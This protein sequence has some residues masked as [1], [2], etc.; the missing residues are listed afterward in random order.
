ML[1]FDRIRLF[2]EVFFPAVA[3]IYRTLPSAKL[4]QHRHRE[5][6]TWP[7][8]FSRLSLPASALILRLIITGIFMTH[9]FL[10][11]FNL[12]ELFVYFFLYSFL[13][14]CCEVI[15]ATLKTGKFVNRGFLNGPV[16]PIYGTGVVLL[17]LCLTPLKKYP[18][19]VFFVSVV[20]CSVL[21]FLTGFLLEKVFH[22]KW[23]DYS[24]RKFNIGGFIC[25]EMSLLWGV[26]AIAVLYGI[27][28][29]FAALLSHIPLLAG[30][31]ILGIC[32]AIFVTDLVFTLLQISALGKRL[33]ELQKINAALRLGSDALGSAL[34]HA[35]EKSA[36][37]IGEIRQSG[38]EKLD[39]LK[40]SGA[41]AIE[42]L[43]YRNAK[44]TDVLYDKIE[45]SRLAKAFP[46]L[47]PSDKRREKVR[48]TI[49]D[50]QDKQENGKNNTNRTGET[51]ISSQNNPKDK[52]GSDSSH[53]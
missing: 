20:L 33:K 43:R 6:L 36:E 53:N 38:S 30:Y 18:W 34:S 11:S 52:D 14:W 40:E 7:R 16:C 24:D 26:A 50:W 22:K 15:F 2:A 23:W 17:L 4:K 37:K 31:I 8:Y 3:N 13:G 29:T 39:N 49:Q 5:T 47:L 9:I 19:A 45:K 35:T 41:Q 44:R 27:Q 10:G 32:A 1:Y 28:P 21:E 25:P 51:D 12:Y 46:A 48:K 42:N